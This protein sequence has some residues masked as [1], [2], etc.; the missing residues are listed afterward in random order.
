MAEAG[1]KAQKKSYAIKNWR[2]YNES[3]VRRGDATFWFS[4]EVVDAWEHENDAK[5]NGRPF[6][7]SDVAIETLLTIRELFRLPYRQTEGLGRAL[8][9]VSCRSVRQLEALIRFGARI[10]RLE[11]NDDNALTPQKRLGLSPQRFVEKLL[12]VVLCCLKESWPWLRRIGIKGDRDI[13]SGEAVLGGQ[14][15]PA[16]ALANPD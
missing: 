11:L 4:E 6:V 15:R 16:I 7:Y 1:S 14:H 3:L 5:K 8:A 13:L 2:E 9:Q 10:Q 12:G